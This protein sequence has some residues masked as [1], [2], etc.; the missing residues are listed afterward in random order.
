MWAVRVEPDGLTCPVAGHQ[1]IG[2]RV[3][4]S[5]QVNTVPR[6]SYQKR[7]FLNPPSTSSTSYVLA[8]VE[9]TAEGENCW[10]TN[11]LILADCH[12]RIELE[13]GIGNRKQRRR[14]LAK[15]NLLIKVLTRFRDAL[16]REIASIEKA[17]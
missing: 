3:F 1:G 14:S 10:T 11:V 4:I 16:I 7:T 5:K 8:E 6:F 13:F 2:P 15:I 17:G 12:R 9:S